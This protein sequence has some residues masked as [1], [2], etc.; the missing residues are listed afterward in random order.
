MTSGSGKQFLK[1]TKAQPGTETT[2]ATGPDAKEP[3]LPEWDPK[4]A[5][6]EMD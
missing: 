3:P 1:M 2:L 6:Q 5:E 4:E